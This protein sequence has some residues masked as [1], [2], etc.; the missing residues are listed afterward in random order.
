MSVDPAAVFDHPREGWY[1]ATDRYTMRPVTTSSGSARPPMH[2]PCG[3]ITVHG[4]GAGDKWLDLGDTAAELASIEVNH[5]RPTGRPNE[6]NT[7]SDTG[8]ETWEWAGPFRAAHDG[9]TQPEGISHNLIDWGHLVVHGVEDLRTAPQWVRDGIVR[10]C[11]RAR[12][13][14]VT[15]G[16]LTV[17]HVVDPHRDRAN[18]GTT[19]PND[20]ADVP[21][22]W[23]RIVLPLDGYDDLGRPTVMPP[24][25]PPEEPPMATPADPTATVTV[26]DTRPPYAVWQAHGGQ[27]TWVDRGPSVPWVEGRAVAVVETDDDDEIASYG[28]VLGPVPDG[29][30][31]WGRLAV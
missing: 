17:E 23:D 20:V 15:A 10:G 2:T 7:A 22:I 12:R 30:D 21:D 1:P 14:G 3:R 5:A 4:I 29:F 9:N 25:T 19:C 13:Q 11:R 18:T 31:P 8:G 24:P 28:P 16:Y 26:K 27:K 6:Y